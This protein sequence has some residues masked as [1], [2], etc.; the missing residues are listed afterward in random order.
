M[1]QPAVQ[2]PAPRRARRPWWAAVLLVVPVAALTIAEA[3]WLGLPPK[4]NSIAKFVIAVSIFALADY[5]AMRDF[6]LQP[7]R[8]LA[9][10]FLFHLAAAL[11]G[12]VLFRVASEIGRM[13]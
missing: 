13:L 11:A 6:A 5:I 2:A 1:D 12:L 10:S 7:R 9:V 4:Q 3:G 8:T